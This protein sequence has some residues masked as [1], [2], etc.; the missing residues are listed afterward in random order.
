MLEPEWMEAPK[1]LLP[2]RLNVQISGA[3]LYPLF[4]D[5]H[6]GRETGTL[7][8]LNDQLR[9]L[10]KQLDC[11]LPIERTDTETQKKCQQ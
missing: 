5:A 7:P 8:G 1:Y 6:S 2:A 3:P 4:L 10:G 9:K 11:A